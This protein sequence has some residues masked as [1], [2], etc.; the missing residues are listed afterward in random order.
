[1]VKFDRLGGAD[2]FF[3]RLHV[4]EEMLR[5]QHDKAGEGHSNGMYS[6]HGMNQ[7]GNIVCLVPSILAMQVFIE[8]LGYTKENLEEIRKWYEGTGSIDCATEHVYIKLF[9][10]GDDAQV[11]RI[12]EGKE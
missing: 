6:Y 11:Q 4:F 2:S 9:L 10:Q 1:M 5:E 8:E 3:G 12:L 7:Y